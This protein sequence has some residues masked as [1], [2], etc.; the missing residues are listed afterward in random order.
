MERYRAGEPIQ[1]EARFLLRWGI[2]FVFLWFGIDKFVHP[3]YWPMWVPEHLPA[4]RSSGALAA[5]GAFEI[6]VGLALLGNVRI[7]EVSAAATVFMGGIV[8]TSGLAPVVR[9][10][11]LIA[12]SAYLAL[13]SPG[14][15]PRAAPSRRFALPQARRRSVLLAGLSLLV[16]VGVVAAGSSLLAAREPTVATTGALLEFTSP[17]DGAAIPPGDLPVT[18]RLGPQSE[19]II[20]NHVHFKVDGRVVDA[21]FLRD[22]ATEARTLLRGLNAG[23]HEITAYLAYADHTEHPGSR[24]SVRVRAS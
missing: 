11:G 19:R 5:F 18:V 9:D 10:V 8:A 4:L 6:A 15:A 14:R 24:T 13:T 17:A 12:A 16:V 1:R 21:V 22:G 2:G 3:A 20:A 23:D 7:R